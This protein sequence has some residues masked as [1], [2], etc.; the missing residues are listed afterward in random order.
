MEQQEMSKE[1]QQEFVNF[2]AQVFKVTSMEDLQSK[3]EEAQ[4]Q[5]PTI[6]KDLVEAFGKYKAQMKTKDKTMSA[7]LGAKLSYVNIL[8]GKCPEGFD[9]YKKGGCIK[10]K[11][12]QINKDIANIKSQIKSKHRFTKSTK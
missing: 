5:N 7:K 9:L 10:C 4:K 3:L 2:L 1:D 6:M 11:K 12:Q 8:N